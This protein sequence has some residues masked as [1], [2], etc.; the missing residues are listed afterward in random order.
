MCRIT[1][2]VVERREP[3]AWLR[4]A[5]QTCRWERPKGDGHTRRTARLGPT[6]IVR[7][8]DPKARNVPE[9]SRAHAGLAIVY[10]QEHGD[11][12]NRR[13]VPLGRAERAAKRAVELDPYE[14]QAHFALAGFFRFSGQLDLFEQEAE[15]T[16]ELNPN[17]AE[18]WADF[19]QSYQHFFG[20]DRLEEGAEMVRRALRLSPRATPWW[21]VPLL[22]YRFFTG[23]YRE[24]LSEL[25]KSGYEDD[26]QWGWYW[27]ALIP[28]LWGDSERARAATDRLLELKPDF[29]MA[30][31]FDTY[32]MHPTY[33]QAY[34][35]AATKAGLPLGDLDGLATTDE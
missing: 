17:Y 28:A 11:G 16:L 3:G 10:E 26:M 21:R 22:R 35:E 4:T 25:D 9:Y 13:P 8:A 2:A 7:K 20:M 23:R 6:A 1:V 34:I 32:Q 14:P 33:H 19:G 30:W 12:L 24:A 29:T 27:R 15:R 18:A 5:I 31:V